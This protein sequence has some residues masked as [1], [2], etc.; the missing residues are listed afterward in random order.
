MFVRKRRYRRELEWT[1]R[2]YRNS[3][4][5]GDGGRYVRE[6]GEWVEIFRG[7]T[8]RTYYQVCE[9][10]RDEQGRPR[11]RV[12]CTLEAKPLVEQIADKRSD[13][14]KYGER[15]PEFVDGICSR[16]ALLERIRA[17]IGDWRP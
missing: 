16:I 5:D 12:V 4:S 14:Q 17:H 6:G 11:Q 7:V 13:L 9:S 10:Y 8:E 2:Q 3:E 15:Y 1:K